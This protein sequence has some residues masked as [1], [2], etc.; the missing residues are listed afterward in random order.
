MVDLVGSGPV[1]DCND[2][3]IGW[4][5]Q[6]GKRDQHQR[7]RADRTLA[8]HQCRRHLFV[9]ASRAAFSRA[10]SSPAWCEE[11][12]S[13]LDDTIRKPLARAIAS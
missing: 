8:I 6:G 13:G 5:R 1:E 11:R 4:Q 12:V 2:Q 10:K 7:G 9:A 3:Q